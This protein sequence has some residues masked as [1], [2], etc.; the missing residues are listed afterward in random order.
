M[1]HWLCFSRYILFHWLRF[2]RVAN[3]ACRFSSS[4][5]EQNKKTQ[6]N[7]TT[8]HHP[9]IK[10]TFFLM[11]FWSF[12]KYLKFSYWKSCT[13]LLCFFRISSLSISCH[14]L[15]TFARI[16]SPL[17]VLCSL[18]S[19]VYVPSFSCCSSFFCLFFSFPRRRLH[20][21]HSSFSW[22][23]LLPFATSFSLFAFVSGT[24]GEDY[25][26]FLQFYASSHGS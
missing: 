2:L 7:K 17:R 9:P 25:S 4:C 1:F 16:F 15:P 14:H 22:R 23:W 24:H 19:F 3:S 8:N 26:A 11:I 18:A 6:H 12:L 13:S 21:G 5:E 20:F 10:R